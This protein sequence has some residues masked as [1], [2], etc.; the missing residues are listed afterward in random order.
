M[1]IQAASTPL[2][3]RAKT[4]VRSPDACT[5][6]NER[7]WTDAFPAYTPG[8]RAGE[9]QSFLDHIALGIAEAARDPNA[10]LLFSGGQT[11]RQAGPRSEVGFQ[12]RGS[13][14]HARSDPHALAV[15][16]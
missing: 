4:P 7:D 16:C 12:T 6:G 3:Y 11:R 1:G 14:Q 5:H 2:T 13:L 15:E 10:L 8:W 9:A